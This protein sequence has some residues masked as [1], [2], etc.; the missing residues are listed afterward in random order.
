MFCKQKQFAKNISILSPKK[1][2]K[3]IIS[4]HW[5]QTLTKLIKIIIA[6]WNNNPILITV[7][8]TDYPIENIS[9]PTVTI[10]REFN[11]QNCFEFV[12][13]IFDF[14]DFPCLDDG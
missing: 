1:S 9:F 10:C 4:E 5:A 6:E 14:V 11:E 13:K 12:T 2:P 7:E 8:T 3:K